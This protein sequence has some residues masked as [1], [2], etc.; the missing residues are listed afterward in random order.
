[1]RPFS[2][3]NIGDIY[4][5]GFGLNEWTVINKNTEE[6][7]IEILMIPSSSNFPANLN[8][9]IW[10]RNTDRIFNNRVYEAER[11]RPA[12]TPSPYPSFKRKG[13]IQ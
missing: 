3:I 11:K 1:M 13:F 7:M 9:S 5:N 10:K 4:S 12:P 2:N 8:R 6:K